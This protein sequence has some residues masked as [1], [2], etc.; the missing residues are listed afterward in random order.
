VVVV[1]KPIKQQQ[2]H[3]ILVGV[4]AVVHTTL[5]LLALEL[6]AHHGKGMMV[7]RV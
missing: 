7:A 2:L 4:G 6:L 1:Q 5:S 3:L